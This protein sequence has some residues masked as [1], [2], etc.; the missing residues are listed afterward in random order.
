MP[1]LPA[2]AAESRTREF[3]L[4]LL[5]A[6]GPSGFESAAA[7]QWR[8]IAD[9]FASETWV[10]SLG[11]SFAACGPENAPVV[12]LAGHI[13]EIGLMVHHI[14]DDG[15]LFVS[16]VG[17]WDTQ[18][19]VG[20]RVEF[21]SSAAAP[22]PAAPESGVTG[23]V[24]RR[25]IH[26]LDPDERKK[27]VS[28]KDLWVDIGVSSGDEAREAV[29]VGDVGVVRSDTLH[30]GQGRIAGRSVDDRAGATVAL[31][32][33]RRAADAGLESVRAVAVATTREEIGLNSGGGARPSAFRLAPRAAVAIDVTH[34]TDHPKSDKARFGDV[35]L[36]G[37][38]VLSRGSNLD[39]H[40]TNALADAAREGG[41]E[42]QWQASA[43]PSWT[44]ADSIFTVAGGVATALISVPNRYMHSPN[45]MIDLEDLEGAASLLAKYLTL[46]SFDGAERS[47]PRTARG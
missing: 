31:E 2:P 22:G 12:M 42:V 26:L 46:A 13:D 41:L 29:A 6:P 35:K 21:I 28:F 11:N 17:G 38:P 4:R 27:A 24:G 44:D 14:D 47:P 9:E 33:L 3:L 5:D 34:A 25:A 16:P 19:L 8:S 15:F 39:A 36:G 10:D 20:Q 18:V 45:Q 23:V 7:A 32:A 1:D 43:G 30:L 37:G 40:L